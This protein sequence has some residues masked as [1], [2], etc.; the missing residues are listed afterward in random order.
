LRCQIPLRLDFERT[1]LTDMRIAVILKRWTARRG[2]VRGHAVHPDVIKDLSDLP[3]LGD[4]C[5]Q[6]HLPISQRAQQRRTW[7]FA[8]NLVN[9]RD[10]HRPQVMLAAF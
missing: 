7:G 3:A 2:N 9:A 8:K 4:K 5:D 6:A 1:I 10:Q